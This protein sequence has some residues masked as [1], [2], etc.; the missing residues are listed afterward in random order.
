RVVPPYPDRLQLTPSLHR[1]GQAGERLR[2]EFLPWLCRVGTDPVQADHAAGIQAAPPR[3]LP[4]QNRLPPCP[5]SWLVRRDP[6]AHR[7][8]DLRPHLFLEAGHQAT[9]RASSDPDGILASSRARNSSARAAVAL[10]AVDFGLY[11]MMGFRYV[12]ASL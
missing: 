7:V 2:V 9:L 3:P 6:V 10:P 12:T 1:I 4:L 11:S 5:A 8:G